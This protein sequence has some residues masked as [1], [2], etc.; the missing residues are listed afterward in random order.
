MTPPNTRLNLLLQRPPQLRS[1]G[2]AWALS[3]LWLCACGDDTEPAATTDVMVD[4][5]DVTDA[6][7]DDATAGPIAM[8]PAEQGPWSVSYAQ[9]SVVVGERTLPVGIWAPS[10]EPAAS[11]GL[12]ALVEPA[13]AAEMA[14]LLEA[15]PADCP[16]RALDVALDAP[17]ADGTWPLVVYSHCH[18]CLGVSGASVAARLASWGY[19][20]LTPD[21]TGNTLWNG[22]ADDGVALNAAFLEVRG[23]DIMGVLDAAGDTAGPLADVAAHVDASAAAV[24]G[25]SFGSVTAGWVAERDPR[26]VAAVAIAAPI[27][28]PLLAG[29]TAANIDVPMLF[30]VAVEDNSISEIGNRLLRDNYESTSAAATK[31][32]IADAGHWSVSDLCGLVDAFDAGCGEANRQTNREQFT[33][34]DAELGREITAT[35]I[36]GYLGAHMTQDEGATAWLDAQATTPEVAVESRTA[37]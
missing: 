8:S 36:A 23:N 34:L 20:V 2:P 14:T 21:H 37:E 24:V 6:T 3:L 7:A 17:I 13:R 11:V 10:L 29:V 28:N 33:Y 15:A 9:T 16:T 30:L 18:E 31:I 26:V 1:T 4:A 19:V 5:A 12:D 35:W 32:E 22:I 27:E 25:H